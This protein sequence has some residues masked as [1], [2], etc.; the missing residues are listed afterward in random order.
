MRFEDSSGRFA[1]IRN[2]IQSAAEALK[3]E[4]HT[5]ANEKDWQP[6]AGAKTTSPHQRLKYKSRAR[7]VASHKGMKAGRPPTYQPHAVQSRRLGGLP[8]LDKDDNEEHIVMI[9]DNPPAAS[10]SASPTLHHSNEPRLAFRI[11]DLDSYTIFTEERGFVSKI[12][13][14]WRGPTMTPLDPNVEQERNMILLF[15]NAHMSFIGGGSP[16]K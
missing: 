3:L 2:I 10:K 5:R 1:D 16:C 8:L 7:E 11:W 4:L 6:G 9:E 12:F 15:T 13:S 14:S